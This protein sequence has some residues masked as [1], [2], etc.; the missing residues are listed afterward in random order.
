VLDPKAS[1]SAK[2]LRLGRLVPGCYALE[3]NDDVPEGI[4]G[5]IE[6]FQERGR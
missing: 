1:W 3:L 5:E 6:E 2:W 4:V